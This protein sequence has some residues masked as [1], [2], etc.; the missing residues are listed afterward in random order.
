MT[1]RQWRMNASDFPASPTPDRTDT[2][3]AAVSF[4]ALVDLTTNAI[5]YGVMM[6][7]ER[8][9]DVLHQI[10]AAGPAATMWDVLKPAAESFLQTRGDLVERLTEVTA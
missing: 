1:G 9:E 4:D 5:G 3:E 2:N 8:R 6:T 10:R 7:L